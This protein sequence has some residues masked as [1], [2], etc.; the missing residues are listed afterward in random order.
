MEGGKT[1]ENSGGKDLDR[2][3]G[4]KEHQVM[5]GGKFSEKFW[6]EC[7]QGGIGMSFG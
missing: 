5:E 6:R 1:S 3:G 7:M 4:V 2:F